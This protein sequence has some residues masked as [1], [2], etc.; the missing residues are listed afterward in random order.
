MA[1]SKKAPT[2]KKESKPA[3][4]D[5]EVQ[6]ALAWLQGHA[7]TK[8]RDE[9][10]PRYGVH[11]DKAFGTS[12]ADMQKLAKR[13]GRQHA[14]AVALWETGWYE[15]RMLAALV[16]EPERVTPPQMDRW[17]KD[18]DNWGICDTV[19]FCLFD[20]TPHA[21][22]KVVQWS[23]RR[24]EFVRR[25]AFA[26]LACLAL[27]D[28]QA[29]NGAFLSCLPLIEKAADDERNFVKKGVSWA[30]RA[31]GTRDAELKAAAVALAERLLDHPAAA[32][33]WIAR[34]ALRALKRA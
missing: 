22:G 4:I 30:L 19:C 7:T 1:G 28:R 27:H 9:M 15:A 25:G 16:D 23:R 11:T 31:I 2:A 6:A 20:R 24:D 21:F 12:M 29:D 10:A 17:A 3:P 18:F 32:T 26:L 13:L 8:R 33:R 14:L 34:D 5:A